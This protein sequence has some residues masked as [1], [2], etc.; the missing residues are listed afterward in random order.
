MAQQTMLFRECGG[1]LLCVHT[2][3]APTKEEWEAYIEYCLQLPR[4]VN[5][6]AVFTAGGGPDAAQRKSL[7][8]RYLDKQKAHNK[9]YLVAVLTDSAFVRGIVKALNWFN[10]YAD[11]F[12]YDKGSGVPAALK[13]LR[14]DGA[15]AGRI[16]LELEKMRRELGMK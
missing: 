5:K 12:P 8:D 11:S 2:A 7:Q 15:A 4:S 9:E 16:A 6:T 13:H 10:P 3:A 1:V 14:I